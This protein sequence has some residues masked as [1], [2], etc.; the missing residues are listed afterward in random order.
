MLSL[1]SL[2]VAQSRG[3]WGQGP[4]A[5]QGLAPSCSALCKLSQPSGRSLEQR[6]GLGRARE[7]SVIW[8]VPPPGAC[9]T[10]YGEDQEPC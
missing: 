2:S 9:V 3:A 10:A 8:A 4:A 5:A 7:A 1:A 6:R